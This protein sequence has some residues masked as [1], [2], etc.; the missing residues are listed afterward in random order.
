MSGEVPP[1]LVCTFMAWKGISLRLVRSFIKMYRYIPSLVKI[2][3][4]YQAAISD[5]NI[6]QQYQTAVSDTLHDD[7]HSFCVHVGHN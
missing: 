4:Q 2:R 6:G 7:R 5:S 3:Q 1:L